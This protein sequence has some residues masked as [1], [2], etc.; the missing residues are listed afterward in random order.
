MNNRL[1]D[2]YLIIVLG[3]LGYALENNHYPLPPLLL[4]F[5][6]GSDTELYLRRSLMYY[7]TFGNC[8]KMIGPGT[9]LVIAAV[10]VTVVALA[11]KSDKL[12]ARFR[13]KGGAQ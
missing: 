8:M 5:I 12:M 13:R 1:F 3:I 6:L 10:A 7:G 4:G 11:M 2:F 9:I